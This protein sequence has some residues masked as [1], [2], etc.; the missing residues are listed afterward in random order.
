MHIMSTCSTH[1][2][3]SE[4]LIKN[5]VNV[6]IILEKRQLPCQDCL[7]V[8]ENDKLTTNTKILV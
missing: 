8:W 7:N 6:S 2:Y 4:D 3:L 1:M 5:Y